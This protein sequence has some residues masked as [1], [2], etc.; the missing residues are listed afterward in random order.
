MDLDMKTLLSLLVVL[1]L[2]ACPSPPASP[3]SQSGWVELFDGSTLRGWTAQGEVKWRVENGAIVADEGEISLL[4]SE[5]KYL[6][7]ELE[8][9]FKAALNT[10]SGVFL[11]SEPV[12][13][14]EATDCYEVNI[15]PPTNDFPTGSLVRFKRIEGQGE[16][17]IW[18]SY[19]LRVENGTVTVVLDGKQLM[20]HTVNPPRP[21]GY[22][23]L[24]KNRGRIAFRNIRIRLL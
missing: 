6:N 22:I 20:E 19:Q 21:A 24:Q 17:D 12:V 8:L 15:A 11:N 5:Q 13:K 14:D 16:K 23:G 3:E 9:E 18:R 1:V 2:S 7:Y 4:T 10:N